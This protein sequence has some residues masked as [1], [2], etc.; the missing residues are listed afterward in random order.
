M[1]LI[2]LV[3]DV[4]PL[5]ESKPGNTH[6][7]FVPA[8]TRRQGQCE[9]THSDLSIETRKPDLSSMNFSLC[10]SSPIIS[11]LVHF[12]LLVSLLCP[13]CS[14]EMGN[15][16]VANHTFKPQEQIHKMNIIRTRLQQ[17]NKPGVKTIQVS[18]SF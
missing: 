3:G 6:F 4:F 10:L 15:T 11:T 7:C 5:E 2:D 14:S 1:C 9:Q 8:R 18:Q 16:P 13:V 12:L 17:I